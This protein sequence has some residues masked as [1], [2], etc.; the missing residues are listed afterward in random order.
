M[1]LDYNKQ[2]SYS[3]TAEVLNLEPLADKWRAFNFEVRE[4]DGH[5]VEGIKREL[6]LAPF[7]ADKPSLLICHTVKGKGV[8][9]AERNLSWHHKNKLTPE[10]IKALYEAVGG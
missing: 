3:T 5:D 8:S 10:E 1:L 7:N 4:V 6:L 2:Q 9:F